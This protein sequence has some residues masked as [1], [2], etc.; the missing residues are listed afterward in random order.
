MSVENQDDNPDFDLLSEELRETTVSAVSDE[1]KESITQDDL[2]G[3]QKSMLAYMEDERVPLEARVMAQI[4]YEEAGMVDPDA[5]NDGDL[6]AREAL[7]RAVS[8]MTGASFTLQYHMKKLQEA[9][10]EGASA[11]DCASCTGEEPSTT[12]ESS[13]TDETDDDSDFSNVGFY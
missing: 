11:C 3:I 12:S 10:D 13:S 2:R 1:F 7:G 5:W 4:A 9:R 8:A 6:D